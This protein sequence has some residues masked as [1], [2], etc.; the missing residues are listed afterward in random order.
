MA[1][2]RSRVRCVPEY[3]SAVPPRA[4]S[5]SIRTLPIVF[6]SH[7]GIVASPK[8]LATDLINFSGQALWLID[9][10]LS[11][12]SIKVVQ[13]HP[14]RSLTESTLRVGVVKDEFP[15]PI[16]LNVAVWKHIHLVI[17]PPFLLGRE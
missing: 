10:C 5:F 13:A 4:R 9:S 1:T 2:G 7:S 12:D 8:P 17:M 3:T 15:V 14:N 11:Q 16:E 6:P